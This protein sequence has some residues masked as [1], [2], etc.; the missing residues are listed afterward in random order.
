MRTVKKHSENNPGKLW[1][2]ALSAFMV[3]MLA[4]FLAAPLSGCRNSAGGGSSESQE[5]YK[6]ATE[7]FFLDRGDGTYS[8]AEAV[9]PENYEG[10]MPLIAIAHGFKGTLNSGGAKELSQ[11]L[12]EAGYAAV[13]MDF[14]PRRSP[15]KDAPK[16]DL[17]DLKSMEDDMVRA[18]NYM[19]GH[20][21]I[22]TDRLGLYARSMGGRVAMTMAN[23]QLGGFDFKAMALVAPAGTDDAMVYYM[24]G[25]KSWE[26]MKKTASR[27]GFIEHQGQKLTPEW[28]KEFEDYNPCDFG[29]KFGDRP[30]LV[31]CNT[32]DY[33]VTDE[34]SRECA[35]AY[36]NSRVI[37]VTTD[38]YHGYEM[39]YEKSDLKDYLMSEI[40]DFFR[41]NL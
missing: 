5:P 13:R 31:I 33:V 16:T 17:Y 1:H 29:Y 10:P 40:T 37:E 18:V 7:E 32:L 8:L 3:L 6:T 41:I 38:N 11:K 4:A 27:E 12:A 24:G 28:F 25:S 21:S 19:I 15:E 34:T 20:H 35:A 26:E 36:K 39:G 9:Y 14:N 23:E 22:D 2:K 30:V